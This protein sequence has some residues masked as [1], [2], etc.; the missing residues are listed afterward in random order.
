MTS[1]EWLVACPDRTTFLYE[2]NVAQSDYVNKYSNKL[3]T[4]L[5]EQQLLEKVKI[6]L[7]EAF[8]EAIEYW[9]R[10]TISGDLMSFT[11]AEVEDFI[12]HANRLMGTTI[13]VDNSG[14]IL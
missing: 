7:L 8:V 4:G 2:L 3:Q 13:Y 6:V 11:V 9:Y 14:I 5:L 10:D 12:Q 1:A